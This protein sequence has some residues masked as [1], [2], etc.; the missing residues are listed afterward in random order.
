MK[1]S[2]NRPSLHGGKCMQR[3]R[4]TT[5]RL[6][7]LEERVALAGDA[8]LDWNSTMLDAVRVDRTPPPRASRIMAIVHAAIYDA[9][10]AIERT[11]GVYLVDAQAGPSTSPEAAV[12]A[13]AHRTLSTLFPVQQATFDAALVASLAATPD[14]PPEDAGV[15]LG[16]SVADRILAIRSA[17]GANDTVAYAS[18]SQPGDW[19]P[20]PPGLLPAL[21]PQWP[22]VIPWTM[23]TGSQFRPNGIPALDSVEYAAALNE[24]LAI[25]SA[26]STTRTA[27]Q[28]AIA[29]FW[30]NGPG[31]ST[32]PGHLNVAARIAAEAQG[33]TLSENA[34]LFAL[35]NLA[36]ADAAIVAW[37]AKYATNFWRPITA[38]RAADTDGNPATTVDPA[39]TPLIG[40]P[41]FPTYTS[42]HSSFS[43]AAAAVLAEFFD[44]DSIAFTLPSED[45]AVADRSYTGFS[46]AAQESAD[47]RLYG[48]IHFRFD[49][50]DG[51]TSGTA[52]GRYVADNFL[53]LDPN[54]D[55]RWIARIY[56]DLLERRTDG[57]GA[58][59]WLAQVSRGL[60][61]AQA[62]DAFLA[63]PE[64]LQNLVDDVYRSLLGRGAEVE[65]LN[66]WRDRL[67]RGM[68]ESEFIGRVLASPEYDGRVRA[69][70]DNYV[71]GLYADLLGREAGADEQAYWNARLAAGT[72]TLDV[73][74][75][76]TGSSEFLGLL[77]DDPANVHG[78]T[79][80]YQ[81]YLVRNADNEG[82]AHWQARLVGGS[83]WADVQRALLV[84]NENL[85]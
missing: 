17:D 31:T 19:V 75:G 20:T 15:A 55:S 81:N 64:S 80:W 84:S 44:T 29:L 51:L 11:H 6:E 7:S 43:G 58:H 1:L 48:G 71:H 4:G 27:D 60:T 36:E 8:V 56:A 74:L 82:R 54:Q 70:G 79:G 2:A 40:T 9:V 21:L 50:Q 57:P 83:S 63:S 3:H 45:A 10:N 65:G 14:G 47:S 13:A 66:F 22:G 52:L 23:T 32:P 26:G 76:F 67:S 73:A 35:L 39:W 59:H 72:S 28:T 41:N 24:V 33:N 46:Q 62:I 77:I 53:L 78:F 37:D 16:Q 85:G 49:N 18:G 30:A 69:A 12:A 68:T 61:R 5:L 25:G 34:R 42:G 38:I